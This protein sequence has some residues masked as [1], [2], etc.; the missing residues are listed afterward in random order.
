MALC[1]SIRLCAFFVANVLHDK[2]RTNSKPCDFPRVLLDFSSENT[3]HPSCCLPSQRISFS[4]L[5][6]FGMR[7]NGWK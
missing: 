3:W 2:V 4:L 7:R 1:V 5:R 6:R